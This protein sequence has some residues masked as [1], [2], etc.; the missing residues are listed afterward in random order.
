MVVNS[1]GGG[2]GPMIVPNIKE[3]T[4]T[5]SLMRDAVAATFR[6]YKR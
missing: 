3:R 2:L 4:I 1:G 5:Q 6:L